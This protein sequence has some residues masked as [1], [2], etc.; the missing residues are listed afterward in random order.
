MVVRNI[1]SLGARRYRGTIAGFKN[2]SGPSVWRVFGGRQ[3][4]VRRAAG[5][6]LRDAMIGAATHFTPHRID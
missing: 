4:P 6:R 2:W 5:F 1:T 3:S